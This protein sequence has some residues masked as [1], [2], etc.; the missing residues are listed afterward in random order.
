MKIKSFFTFSFMLLM[1]LNVTAQENKRNFKIHTVAFYN[2]ENL[3]DT[4]ND[5]NKND[6]ASP[7]MEIRF[8]RGKIYREKVSNMANVISQIGFDVTKRPPSIL[9]I[10]EVENRMVV[11][12]LISDEKLRK[13]NYGIV[14]Y[15]SPDDRGIDVGLIYNKD[16][17]KV[18]NSNSHDVFITGN[19]SSKRRNTRDQ[20]VVSGYLDGEL[21][22]FI[23]NH[24]PSRGA[25]ETKR[26]AAAEVNNFIIDSLRSKY[27]N[28]KMITM[29]D[30]NDDPF[31]KS[32]KK[33]LGA[34]KNINDVKKNDMYNPFETILVDE[35]VGSNAYRDK[36]QLFD[37]II[38]SKPF[39]DKNYKDYQLYKAGVFNKSFLI[40]KK[41][42]FKGYPFRSFSYGTFTGGY[43][44]HLPP[45]IYLLKEIK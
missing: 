1:L 21:M 19:N 3:F 43:S 4:I 40:N 45:Y 18:K 34:K 31:D 25:D 24:W 42:K 8:N 23:V 13:Y 41:G 33:I 28:P 12:D 37:Q 11:E 10:C 22:H 30:F 6:E 9:G 27:E 38:L 5:E 17:F 26:I 14:H 7:I 36:W 32:I 2:L 35:G 20:L 39:L 29:G 16:V 15:E 44:D